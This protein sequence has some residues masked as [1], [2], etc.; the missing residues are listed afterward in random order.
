MCMS[1]LLNLEGHTKLEWG[2]V[3][4]VMEVAMIFYVIKKFQ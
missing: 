3:F 2:G 1:M 4:Q